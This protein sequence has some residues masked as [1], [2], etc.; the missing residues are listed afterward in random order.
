MR[1]VLKSIL[2]AMLYYS[3]LLWLLRRS[4]A[5][6]GEAVIVTYHAVDAD[7]SAATP[8]EVEAGLAVSRST[9]R[10]QLRH[11]ARRYRIVPLSDLAR[12]VS[13]GDCSLGGACAVTF[14]DALA[15]LAENA[16]PVL[17]ELGI[18]AT[19]FVPSDYVGRRE[20]LPALRLRRVI[21]ASGGSPRAAEAYKERG[22]EGI[23]AICD[24]IERSLSEDQRAALDALAPRRVMSA[25]ELQRLRQSGITIGS[26][27]KRHDPLPCLSE[28]ARQDEI[29]GSK[30]AIEQLANQAVDCFCYPHGA[31]DDAACALVAGARYACA[32]TTEPGAVRTGDCAHALR[33]IAADENSSR[34]L[35]SAFSP[36]MFEL[37]LLLQARRRRRRHG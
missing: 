9:L 20:E 3:G 7:L 29:I 12:A 23:T 11:L 36:G 16:L 19:V 22:G 2:A 13:S 25:G 21:W 4:A 6:H 28:D 18:P 24:M 35:W 8:A 15:G 1:R 34:G 10:R 31:V 5:R 17:E 27:G 14:D 32:C 33:R 37:T 30:A 26:H